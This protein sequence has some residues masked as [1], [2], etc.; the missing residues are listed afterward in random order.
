MSHPAEQSL[1]GKQASYQSQY[2]AS[3]LFAI[4]RAGKWAELGLTADSLPWQ[5]M[6]LWT[7]YELSWLLPS[8]KPVVAMAE[9]SVPA[10]SPCIIESK[11]FKLYLNSF[12][13]T[14]FADAAAVTAT[15]VQDLS[16]IAGAQVG[17]QLMDLNQATAQGL[18]QLPGL[19]VDELDV[20]IHQ[21]SNPSADLLSCVEDTAHS[22]QLHSH[23]LRSLCPVTGQPDWGSVLIEYSGNRRLQPESLLRYLVSFREH[24]DFHEHCAERI[25]C[26]LSQLL[27]PESLSVQ[28]RYLRRGGLDINPCRSNQ[29][30]DWPALRLVRQ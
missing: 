16:A 27:Q 19:C 1:L 24:Q 23:L 12:N 11:S 7:A 28:A 6:D 10:N 26:D 5:G 3:L 9:F 2:D 4:E 15:L 18:A 21:H 13:Q 22:Q 14:V 20:D 25:Y 29:A 17:V 8:G 30:R